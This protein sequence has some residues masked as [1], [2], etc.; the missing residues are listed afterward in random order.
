MNGAVVLGYFLTVGSD[1]PSARAISATVSPRALLLRILWIVGMSIISFLA[2]FVK[3]DDSNDEDS[4]GSGRHVAFR[5]IR[6]FFFV[7][8]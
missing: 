6:K 2:S 7:I 5:D 1:T 4:R 8:S 3:T